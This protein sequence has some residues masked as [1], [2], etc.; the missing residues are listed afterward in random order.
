MSGF[1]LVVS[2]SLYGLIH[3]TFIGVLAI[4]VSSLLKSF[5]LS[6]FDLT[7]SIILKNVS[8]KLELSNKLLPLRLAFIVVNF[9]SVLFDFGI[10]TLSVSIFFRILGCFLI[11]CRHC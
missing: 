5:N 8:S 4:N 9:L 1:N 7:V 11:Q 3:L 2:C 6:V 10:T